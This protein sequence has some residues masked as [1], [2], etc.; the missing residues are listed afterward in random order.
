MY[1]GQVDGMVVSECKGSGRDRLYCG[2]QNDRKLPDVAMW[3]R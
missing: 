2:R 3:K 1:S